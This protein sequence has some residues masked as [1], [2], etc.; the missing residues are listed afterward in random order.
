MKVRRKFNLGRIGH[1]YESL[2]IEVE[3]ETIDEAAELI[4]KAWEHYCRLVVEDKIQ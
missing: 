1:Q 3:A 4:E 2:D